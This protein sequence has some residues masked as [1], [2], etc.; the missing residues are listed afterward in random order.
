MYKL[1]RNNVSKFIAAFTFHFV[2]PLRFVVN[3]KVNHAGIE[4]CCWNKSSFTVIDNCYRNLKLNVSNPKNKF[5]FI[6]KC[7]QPEKIR[8]NNSFLNYYY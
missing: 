2:F 5:S 7:I 3:F 6:A 1:K 4:L 8:K